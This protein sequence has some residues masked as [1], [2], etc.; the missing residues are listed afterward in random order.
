MLEKW[1]SHCR[2][3]HPKCSKDASQP[4]PTRVIDVKD[5]GS[6]LSLLL[7]N[8]QRGQYITLSHC[9]GSSPLLSTTTANIRKHLAEISI[10]ELPR[11]FQDAV[12]VTRRL[13]FRYLWIDSLCIIQDS[14]LDWVQESARM[15]AIYAN[16]FCTIA[17]SSAVG[18]NCGFLLPKSRLEISSYE[19]TSQPSS[20]LAGSSP[21][22]HCHINSP[23]ALTYESPDMFE[24]GI[25]SMPLNRRAWALQE[26]ILSSRIIHFVQNQV[27]WECATHVATE[28]D[29]IQAETLHGTSLGFTRSEDHYTTM[30]TFPLVSYLEWYNILMDYTSRALTYRSDRLPAIWALAQDIQI[31]LGG[32][33]VAGLFKEDL[34][35]GMLFSRTVPSPRS[36]NPSDDAP[37][38]SWASLEGPVKWELEI[39]TPK[40]APVAQVIGLH[41]V[42]KASQRPMGRTL[43]AAVT[44]SACM[45]SVM[46][47]PPNAVDFKTGIT[48]PRRVIIDGEAVG[49][50]SFDHDLE[51][52]EKTEET[53][54]IQLAHE[55]PRGL[56]A[57]GILVTPTGHAENEYRRVGSYE[58]F[59]DY[60]EPGARLIDTAE[61]Q[62][63][64]II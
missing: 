32:A 51:D 9:W 34:I 57:Y 36:T 39:V 48:P 28:F 53:L 19:G 22:W 3:N 7:T 58:R 6:V 62:T 23:T 15:G 38:W 45:G 16:A 25:R 37:S 63:L 49:W 20:N 26:R 43:R 4:L 5:D 40:V 24:K 64:V 59:F 52:F 42:E 50:L 60:D 10:D 44:L 56:R 13:G 54:C 27:L 11:N 31:R 30:K 2:E 17:A 1:L 61:R 35:R 14:E 55:L 46:S 29:Y 47:V 21:P 41:V 18:G 33:Y 12:T 8:G